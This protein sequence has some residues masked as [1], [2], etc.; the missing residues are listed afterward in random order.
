MRTKNRVRL[1]NAQLDEVGATEEQPG[2]VVI[3]KVECKAA[4][5]SLTATSRLGPG[6][7][8]SA[9]HRDYQEVLVTFTID[10]KKNRMTERSELFELIGAWAQEGQ[11]L[12]I[13][14][15]PNRRLYIDYIEMPDEGNARD[16]VQEY[17]MTMRA[18]S[19][20]YWMEYDGNT[21]SVT[22]KASGSMTCEV[23]GNTETVM[24]VTLKNVSGKDIANVSVTAGKSTLTFKG[25]DF[26]K[27]DE[28]LIE[29]TAEGLLRLRIH[30]ATGSPA[31][32]NVMNK[33]TTASSDDL[34]VSPGSVAVSWTADRACDVTASWRGRFK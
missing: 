1:G 28:L 18:Y 20:P 34:Y 29:H 12:R 33:R 21:K 9:R 4:K 11:W 22:K 14:A 3:Q 8:L 6:Q 24:G 19:V 31:Y 30:R 2:R 5:Q 17:K 16:F 10:L 13:S 26:K 15:K 7:R 27:N 25:L 23:Y 32:V